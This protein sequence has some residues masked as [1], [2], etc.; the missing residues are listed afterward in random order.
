MEHLLILLKI[1]YWGFENIFKSSVSIPINHHQQM[2][3]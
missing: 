2:S 3:L 1:E